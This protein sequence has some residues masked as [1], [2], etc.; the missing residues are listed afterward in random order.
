MSGRKRR[1]RSRRGGRKAGSAA[2]RAGRKAARTG[3]RAQ[4]KAAQAAPRAGR[5]AANAQAG[6]ANPAGAASHAAAASHAGDP[7]ER[8]LRGAIAV[9]LGL[10]LLTPL[11]VSKSTVF[12]YVVGKALWARSLIEIAFALWAALALARP[13]YRPPGS[14]LLLLLGAGLAVSFASA[15]FGVSPQHSLWSSYERMLGV[16]DQAHWAALALVLASV[17][18]SGRE[19]RALFAANLA[20]GTLM[21]AIVIARALDIEI[22]YY[23]DA[24]ERS[25]SRYGGPFGNPI[26]L[27]VY[28]LA[29]LVLAAGF[30]AR[31]LAGAGP[32]R[33]Y[34][35]LGWSLAAAAQFAG[36]VLAGS[37]GGFVGL[38]AAA[39]CA[40]LGFAWLYRGR[41]RLAA[42]ACLC[43]LAAGV[44]AA[45]A[46][47]FDTSRASTA[48][49][50]DT[51]AELP[52]GRAVRYMSRVHL[53]R[54]SVQSRLAAWEAGLEGFAERPLLG[55]GPGNYATVFGLFGSGYAAAAEPHDR[56]HGN[57][58]EVAATTGTAGLLLWLALWGLAL[59]VLARA[60]RARD[61]PERAFIL[62]AGAALAGHLAQLQFMFDTVTGLMLSTFLLAY[63]ARLEPDLAPANGRR[64][65]LPGLAARALPG[66]RGDGLPE[67]RG[68]GLPGGRGA[69]LPG[70]R[71]AGLPG[72]RGAGLLRRGAPRALLGAAAAGL[73]GWGLAVN[74]A[75]FQAADTRYTEPQSLATGAV[76]E[77]IERF[78]PLA[79]HLR[80]LLFSELA[81]NWPDLR[82][83]HPR[84]ALALLALADREADAA[85]AREPW[86]WQVAHRLARLYAAVAE[87]DPE[88]AE[89]ARQRLERAREL[90]PLRPVFPPELS[91][92]DELTA[93][94]ADGGRLL[95]GWRPARHAGYHEL[96]AT[97]PDGVWSAIA[98]EYDAGRNSR[99]VPAC[100]GCG[101]RIRACRSWSNCTDWAYWP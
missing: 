4:R 25:P 26:F 34:R 88:Y 30:A 15:A 19:W 62:L 47:F 3:P 39:A 42:I 78:P 31:A 68:G 61:G 65:R 9:T 20:V 89:V 35:A 41:A 29:N 67:G 17:L 76:A 70:E 63:A 81:L 80:G 96:A 73:A 91:P 100:E 58:F 98:F 59:A 48:A 6:A 32:G 99:A 53:R 55:W 71:G 11:M 1:Q 54:P 24:A 69:D 21:A 27:A 64:F 51:L 23:G 101:Y 77:G 93:G 72:E 97:T 92:P 18:R 22:P 52:G 46:R 75:A 95:L 14:R 5:K 38:F 40:A 82:P 28:M 74:H 87:T 43:V 33:R 66:G 45:S 90:A 36:L 57:L 85:L 7:L 50:S 86:N 44:T 84:P 60:A 13:A 56:A 79:G 94:A 49:V 37:V 8:L 12:P 83:Q 16:L 2:P 10:L